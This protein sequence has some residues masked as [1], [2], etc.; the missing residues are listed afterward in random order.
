[1]LFHCC[2]KQSPGASLVFGCLLSQES[3]LKVRIFKILSGDFMVG[4]YSKSML[5]KSNTGLK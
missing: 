4:K 3:V 5:M 1:M 2:A